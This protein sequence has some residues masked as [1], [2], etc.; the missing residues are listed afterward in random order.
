[1]GFCATRQIIRIWLRS[2][3]T[4]TSAAGK[5]ASIFKMMDVSRHKAEL[6]KEHSGAGLL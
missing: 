6:F 4:S 5:G 1:M 3:R 2:G